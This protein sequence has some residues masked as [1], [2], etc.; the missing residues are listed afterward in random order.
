MVNQIRLRYILTP[1]ADASHKRASTPTEGS[2]NGSAAVLKTAGR[3]A[4]QVRVLSP[5]PFQINNLPV[6]MS[7]EPL[8]CRSGNLMVPRTPGNLLVPFLKKSLSIFL[9]LTRRGVL[10]SHLRGYSYSE[11]RGS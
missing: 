6:F 2:H 4:M 8:I 9:A 3:K 11:R 1:T 7:L 10:T 5:P